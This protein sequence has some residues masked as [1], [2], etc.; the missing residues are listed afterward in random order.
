MARLRD[1]RYEAFTVPN[2]DRQ[3]LYIF[4][5]QPGDDRLSLP[6]PDTTTRSDDSCG[7]PTMA[8]TSRTS[9]RG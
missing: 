7:Q 6:H 2:T 9:R 3:V 5:A 4:F 1:L 8:S